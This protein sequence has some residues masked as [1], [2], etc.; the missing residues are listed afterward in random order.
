MNVI[1]HAIGTAIINTKLRTGAISTNIGHIPV[2]IAAK[3]P[4]IRVLRLL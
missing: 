2:R 4:V 3:I 1:N